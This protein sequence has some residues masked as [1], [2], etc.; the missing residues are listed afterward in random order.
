MKPNLSNVQADSANGYE[1]TQRMSI[2]FDF[3]YELITGGKAAGR[4]EFQEHVVE[5]EVVNSGNPLYDLLKGMSSLIFEPSHI[6]GED[7][8]SWVDWYEEVG[9]LRWVLSTEDGLNI[10]VKLIK[11][12]DV[13]DESTGSVVAEGLLDMQDFY[14]AIIHKLDKFIKRMG[15]LN[16]EQ[17]WQK[18]E[19]PLTYFLL[20][21]KYLIEKGSWI[22]TNEKVGILSDELDFLIA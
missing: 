13:F 18:D 21:K 4:I 5:F 3:T 1:N 14:Y 12:E 16:Y 8:I 2:P 15:L 6:W 19:F 20:L 17:Q 10:Q 22:P 9:C 7:N 11:Y